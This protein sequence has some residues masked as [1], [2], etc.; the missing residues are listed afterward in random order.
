LTPLVGHLAQQAL[1]HRT[2]GG[3]RLARF[4]PATRVRFDW[5]T[6]GEAEFADGVM[7]VAL[8]GRFADGSAAG[9]T[10]TPK[11][12]GGPDVTMT[13]IGARDDRPLEN[14]TFRPNS[15]GLGLSGGRF[16]QVDDGEALLIRFDRDVIVESAEV[17]AGNGVCG[18][19]YRMADAAALH[20]YCVDADND[21]QDQS[22]VLSDLGVLRAGQTLRLDSSPHLGVE[23]GGRW[24]LAAVTVRVLPSLPMQN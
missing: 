1:L 20:I 18:G 24:R 22:G 7:Q 4:A 13:V 17:V 6:D 15:R 23:S 11:I 10:A 12:A 8:A 3:H 9:V 14:A 19:F 16:D 5:C 21:T 2:A